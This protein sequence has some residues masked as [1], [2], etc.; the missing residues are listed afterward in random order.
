M[1]KNWAQHRFVRSIAT[2]QIST[3][4]PEVTWAATWV[5]DQKENPDVTVQ[6]VTIKIFIK[7][8]TFDIKIVKNFRFEK[9]RKP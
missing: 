8:I 9:L 7:D 4:G 5:W 3:P 1:I 2:R 6:A